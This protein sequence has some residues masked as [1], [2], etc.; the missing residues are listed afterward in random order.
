M[1]YLLYSLFS[2]VLFALNQCKTGQI[3]LENQCYSNMLERFDMQPLSSSNTGCK[4]TL[5]VYE[6]NGEEFFCL[7]SPCSTILV[8]PTRCDGTT[9][10]DQATAE[11]QASF[12]AQAKLV[13]EIGVEQ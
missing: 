5:A 1:K 12:F 8:N 10:F 13:R 2:L 9:Y 3:E 11:K 7:N 6:L 4:I